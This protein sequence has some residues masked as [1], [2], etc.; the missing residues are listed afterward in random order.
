M[1]TSNNTTCSMLSTLSLLTALSISSAQAENVNIPSYLASSSYDK[2]L[3]YS[4]HKQSTVD[5]STVK[6]DIE[7]L[8]LLEIERNKFIRPP[9]LIQEQ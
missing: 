2:P 3:N 9:I 5:N 6:N 1:N 8:K 7:M 4:F